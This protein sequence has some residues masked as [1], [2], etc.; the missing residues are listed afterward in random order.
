MRDRQ[1][2]AGA[3]HQA[4]VLAAVLLGA[5]CA[6]VAGADLQ[7]EYGDSVFGLSGLLTTGAAMRLEN[8]D[9]RFL[10]KTDVPGQQSLCAADDCMSLRGDPA[11]NQRLVDAKGAFS[12]VNTDDGEM[13][14]KRYDLVAATTKLT[15]TLTFENG[16]VSAKLRGIAYYDPRN[17]NFTETRNNTLYQDAHS[18]RPDDLSSRFAAGFKWREAFV[19][20]S[21][22]RGTITVGNQLIPW[23]ESSL[24]QFNTLSAIN[25]LDANVVRMPGAQINEF[26]KAVPA[27]TVSGDLG[28]GFSAEAFYQLQWVRLDPDTAGS[29]YSTNN[30]LGGGEFVIVGLGQYAQDPDREYSPPF[31]NSLISS[32]TRTAYLLGEKY[33]DPRNSGQ[34]GLQLKYYA[35]DFN[36]GTEFG[37]QYLHY[38][39]RVPYISAFA[40]DA[41]CTRMGTPGSFVSALAACNGFNGP[42][43]AVG[44]LEP[45]PVDTL[46][47]FVDY[48]EDIQLFGPSFNTTVGSWSL[49]GEYAYRPNMPLQIAVSDLIFAAESPAFPL[50]DIPVPS[51][52]L[53]SA[54]PFTIPGARTSVPDFISGYRGV[55]IGPNDLIRGYERFHVGQFA[56]TGIRQFSAT[57][58]HVGA[59]ALTLVVEVSG[60]NIFDLPSLDRLQLEGSGDRTHHSAGADGTGDPIG[61]ANSLRINPTQQTRGYATAFSWGYRALARFTYDNVFAG[62]NLQPALLFFHDVHGISL[63][64]APN[65]VQGRKTVYAVLDAQ[66]TQ[67][68]RVNLQYQLFTG[69]GKYN[70]LLDRDNIA[71]SASYAF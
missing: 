6:P 57:D 23:G 46:R 67:N 47:P 43:A 25:P 52:L 64:N 26:M 24:T 19:A 5:A 22:E 27:I 60:T 29:F 7:L 33:G 58:N 63:A 8:P 49:A 53:G 4:A 51:G 61:T 32:A 3:G 18:K 10:G 14:Y 59:D 48:P 15:P 13:N 44:G 38:H 69:G 1:G 2:S 65:Y 54:A 39:S 55:T 50:Q 70:T 11:P 41:S 17:D 62:I 21:N 28:A 31:P 71:L 35:E 68:F 16:P 34:F 56:L 42:G 66:F 30:V 37:F 9:T 36:N 40:A 45:L 12:G 20:L